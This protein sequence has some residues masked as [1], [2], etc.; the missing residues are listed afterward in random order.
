MIKILPIKNILSK[1]SLSSKKSNNKK[2]DFKKALVKELS[3]KIKDL[4]TASNK[5]GQIQKAVLTSKTRCSKKTVAKTEQKNIYGFIQSISIQTE[6]HKGGKVKKGVENITDKNGKN[7]KEKLVLSKKQI[8]EKHRAKTDIK[9]AV[10]ELK[11]NSKATGKQFAYKESGTEKTEMHSIDAAKRISNNRQADTNTKEAADSAREKN[12]KI[13]TEKLKQ[14][15]ADETFGTKQFKKEK[16]YK[17]KKSIQTKTATDKH[18][19]A[20]KESAENTAS[21][22]GGG[23]KTNAKAKNSNEAFYQENPN[24]TDSKQNITL[25][26]T[27]DKNLNIKSIHIEAG[28][29]KSNIKSGR[30]IEVTH[31]SANPKSDTKEYFINL[32]NK[33]K[34]N[35]Y[36]VQNAKAVDITTIKKAGEILTIK[37]NKNKTKTVIKN[38]THSKLDDKKIFKQNKI[39][40]N[41]KSAIIQN[42]NG[43]DTFLPRL[44]QETV[45][46]KTENLFNTAEK[47]RKKE[48]ENANIQIAAALGK[49][50]MQNSKIDKVDKIYPLDK[51]IE[52]IDKIKNLK[53]PFNNTVI[54]KLNPPRLGAI[55]LKVKIDKDKNISALI[56]AQDKDIFKTINAHADKLKNYLVSQGILKQNSA[57]ETFGTKQFK[58]EKDYK[59]KKSIQTKTATDKH[60]MAKKE[61][62]ENTASKNGG[63]AKTNAKA[64]NSNEAF[65]QEN[66]NK[67]DSKQNITLKQTEDKNLNIKSI[68]IEAGT[69]KSNIKSGRHIEV[70]HRSANP[71]SDTKEYFINLHNKEKNN[72]YSVQNAKA[73]DITTIKK[74]GEILTIKKN[75]NK[76]KTVIKNITHSKLD[77][78]K[79]F[80][81]NKIGVNF[82]S[83]IIQ[84]T[85]GVDTFLPRLEQETVK[86]KTEN[87][88]NTAEKIRKKE[89][90][91]ANIQ[92]AAAL[93]KSDM[94]NSKI[95]KVDKIYPLDKIIENIDKIKNLKPPF[96]NTVII[97]LNPP[98]LGAIMLKVKIDKDKNISALID[99]QDKD[100]FKTINAHA[101]KLKNYLVSQGIKIE[102]INV[103]NNFNEHQGF[104]NSQNQNG[105]SGNPQHSQTGKFYTPAE[106]INKNGNMFS[107][108]QTVFGKKQT[109]ALD[110]M[111]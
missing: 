45:K 23:A 93:G 2:G 74:A 84:N 104:G 102:S 56:D 110:I 109:K 16:D 46:L 92:I 88:F 89:S 80:K 25:K 17:I 58:K 95:D 40:V 106:N 38:I 4:N 55:M 51:I 73:V 82:K 77:D 28:T 49:S 47:I 5:N 39:G 100:I 19:M 18:N 57:D 76:T 86:L 107:N 42:T 1:T 75:K 83:A 30:H 35:F 11:S 66:P 101:D 85:N 13:K 15:S 78:K 62:A 22:N 12:K 29:E 63:G 44:E 7:T 108:K 34:N 68:H 53:P 111:V 67:T 97:K 41:F 10:D 105:Y 70:T 91:N 81:Q 103:Q 52:N 32:H 21:K 26:Q 69:E 31:R 65:Y 64:K 3:A 14:N 60:N 48:S 24:K 96:N 50:D 43:V 9:T 61:S 99:A 8:P 33:E 59:I 20:K 6:N 71:K 54:I 98:R 72:F 36:S 79:I 27:E 94:Q 37:K 87:L 90:E